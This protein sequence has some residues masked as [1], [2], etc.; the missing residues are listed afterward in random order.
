V[1]IDDPARTCLCDFAFISMA[2]GAL[3]DAAAPRAG[4]YFS[5]ALA[6]VVPS[7]VFP[8]YRF[9]ECEF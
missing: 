4:L 8:I 3:Y 9:G 6:V 2:A 5:I 7:Y 1:R